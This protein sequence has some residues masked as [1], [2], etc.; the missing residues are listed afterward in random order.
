[1]DT[2]RR[3]FVSSSISTTSSADTGIEGEKSAPMTPPRA[4]TI[5]ELPNEIIHQILRHLEPLTLVRLGATCRSLQTHAENDLLWSKLV[6]GNVPVGQA[7]P[8]PFKSW[9]ELYSS[10]YPYWFLPRYKLWFADKIGLAGQLVIARYDHRFGAIEAY[11]LVAEFEHGQH[12]AH[13][14]EWDPEVL[15]HNFTPR[16]RLFLDNPVIRLDR[17][18]LSQRSCLQQ[19]IPM[20]RRDDQGMHGPRSALCL[21]V[22]IPPESQDP[23]MSLWPPKTIPATNRVRND[24]PSLF[25]ADGHKP[26]Q[27][28]QICETAF[29]VRKWTEYRGPASREPIRMGEDVLTFSSLPPESY[30]PTTEKPYQG[31]WVGD[32]AGHGCEFLLLLQTAATRG[33]SILDDDGQ[34]IQTETP[35]GEPTIENEDPPGCSGRLE[36][37]K[38]TGDPNVPRGEYTW[39]SD[40]IGKGGLIRI[41]D[42]EIFMGARIVRSWGHIAGHG[43]RAGESYKVRRRSDCTEWCR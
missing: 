19:E 9:K 41:A 5:L 33:R 31:I 8:S 24:S 42:E 16:V 18:S 40:D 34:L 26:Q 12:T 20:Q 28:A 14:W 7:S 32:Y 30:T 6:H 1:M 21:T 4:S 13:P 2:L 36:A 29:R 38:L 10:F 17:N 43:F 25:R 39:I 27:F 3:L 23:S 22:S 37:V 35:L 15:I 11:R